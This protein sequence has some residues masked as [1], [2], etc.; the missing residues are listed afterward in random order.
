MLNNHSK[1]STLKR[2]WVTEQCVDTNTGDDAMDE[3]THTL[4]TINST[5]SLYDIIGKS[6]DLHTGPRKLHDT[7]MVRVYFIWFCLLFLKN[8]QCV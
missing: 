5:G 8:I 1:L 2:T 7:R 3:D 4:Q 6:K